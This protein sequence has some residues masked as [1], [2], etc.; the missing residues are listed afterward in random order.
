M[1]AFTVATL[2]LVANLN[3]EA[4]TTSSLPQSRDALTVSFGVSFV[5]TVFWSSTY[6]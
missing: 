5:W 4:F 2:A 1:R 3:V 6:R